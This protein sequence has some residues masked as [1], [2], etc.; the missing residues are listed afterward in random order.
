[1]KKLSS[2]LLIVAAIILITALHFLTPIDRTTAHEIYQRLYYLPIVAAALLFGLRGGGAAALFA[3]LAYV[4]HI[5]FQWHHQPAY[6]L[7]QYAE[8][9]L[10]FFFAL[11]TGAL[12][13]RNRRETARAE[14]N[15]AEL[16]QAYAELRQ[17][18]EQLLQ[19]ERLTALGELSAGIVHEIRNPLGAIKGAVEIVEDELAAN[20][21]RREFIAIAKREV[22]RIEKLVQEFVRFARPPKPAKTFVNANQLIVSLSLLLAQQAAGQSVSIEKCLAETLPLVSLDT[23]QIE[24]VL[25]NLALNALQAMPTGGKL[26]FR[27]F[28]HEETV[29]IEIEDTG[30]G[31]PPNVIKRIFD[32]F[33]TTKEKGLGLGLSIAHKIVSE[34]NGRLLVSN[35]L[36]G[37]VFK[38]VL[39]I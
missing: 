26:V 31:I 20:S 37:V 12:S 16:Q 17:T 8:I 19:A 36:K 32:P 23:E 21:P 30:G 1:M 28:Q 14:K 9:V 18:F 29:I 3:T 10:F 35:T 2:K 7:N 11:V 27:T 22:D 38:I 34:H 4:P 33:F 39:A 5:A 24:Q 13:D 15:A 6:A 25:L